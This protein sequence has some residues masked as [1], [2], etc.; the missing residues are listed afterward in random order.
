[1]GIEKADFPTAEYIWQPIDLLI[2][3]VVMFVLH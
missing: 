3:L 2:R 1:M